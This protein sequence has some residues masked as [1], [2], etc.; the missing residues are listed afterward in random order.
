MA[1]LPI[2]GK[3]GLHRH[4]YQ[5]EVVNQQPVKGILT[6]DYS[7]HIRV[8]KWSNRGRIWDGIDSAK[9]D[10]QPRY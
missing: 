6:H 3:G 2:Q 7:R 10:I 8:S 5:L 1:F 4:L 9:L